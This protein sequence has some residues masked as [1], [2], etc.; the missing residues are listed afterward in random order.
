MKTFSKIKKLYET[1]Q[2]EFRSSSKGISKFRSTFSSNNSDNTDQK[3]LLIINSDIDQNSLIEKQRMNKSIKKHSDNLHNFIKL[4]DIGLDVNSNS[5]TN[6]DENIIS[7]NERFSIGNNS[8]CS[9]T[10]PL[11]LFGAEDKN[12]KIIEMLKNESDSKTPSNI[13]SNINKS[14][15]KVDSLCVNSK[16]VNLSLFVNN[17]IL[18]KDSSPKILPKCPSS[19]PHRKLKKSNISHSI[20]N[21]NTK[22]FIFDKYPNRKK[23]T[24]YDKFINKSLMTDSHKNIYTI[25]IE[26]IIDN[27][28][29]KNFTS[30]VA[31]DIIK[32]EIIYETESCTVYKGSYLCLPVAIKVYNISTLTEEEIVK[33]LN[34][35]LE[36]ICF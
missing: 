26:S 28:C 3:H 29:L 1:Q 32:Q 5:S 31:T 34:K 12:S 21:V 14:N 16:N 24:T 4:A 35:N 15:S 25:N 13:L 20:L 36:K 33:I 30:L 22:D 6:L 9:T 17:N 2:K 10:P 7:N 19:S 11:K 27:N 8:S 23:V 18:K